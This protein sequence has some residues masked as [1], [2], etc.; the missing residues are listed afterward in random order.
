M[1]DVERKGDECIG[2]L[3]GNVEGENEAIWNGEKRLGQK[4]LRK[5]TKVHLNTAKVL[6][7][8]R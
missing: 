2:E 5:R 3:S 7:N 8:Q 1:N 4:G 6:P